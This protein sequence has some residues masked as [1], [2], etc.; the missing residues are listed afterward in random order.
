MTF[1]FPWEEA[2]DPVG[3]ALEATGA[4]LP[5][6]WCGRTSDKDQQDPTQEV[7]AGHRQQ[8]PSS[9]GGRS[10]LRPRV[11]LLILDGYLWAT[12]IECHHNRIWVDRPSSALLA[13]TW[14]KVL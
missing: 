3:A 14:P 10:G 9:A 1:H 12:V 8:P 2:D 13:D 11:T 7:P 4:P 5:V 6:A